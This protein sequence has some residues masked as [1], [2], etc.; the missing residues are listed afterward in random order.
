MTLK[1]QTKQVLVEEG[2]LLPNS[3]VELKNVEM[4]GDWATI[5]ANCY[6]H[7]ARKPFKCHVLKVFVPSGTVFWSKSSFYYL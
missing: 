2:Y 4:I 3:R 6:K 1:E 5:E 7:R